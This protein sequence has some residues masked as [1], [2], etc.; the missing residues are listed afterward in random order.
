[1]LTPVYLLVRAAEQGGRIDDILLDASAKAA[2]VRTIV[3]MASVT[4]TCIA[5]AVPLAWLCVR[6]DVPFRRAW[7]VLLAL[8]LAVPSFIG[9]FVTVS[10]FGPGGML[11]DV[12]EPF[13]VERIPSLYG[14][15]GAWLTLSFFTYPYIFLTVHGALRRIDPS[16]EEAARTLGQGP[17][18][19]FARVTL[20]QLRPAIAA[21]AIL[22]ALYVLSE[23][24]AVSM[25]RYDTLTPLAYIQY[26]TSFDRSAAAVLGLPLLALAVALVLTE[27]LSQRRSRYYAQGQLRP[28]RTVRLGRWRWPAAAFCALVALLGIGAPV[29]VLAYWLIKGLSEGESTSFLGEAVWN[30]VQSSGLAA[31]LTVVAALPIATLSVRHPGRGPQLLT[32]LSYLGQSLPGITVALSL[33]YFAANFAGPIYQ[34]LGLLILAYAIRFLPEAMGACRASLLQVNPHTEE[35]ARGL[36][37]GRLRVF[38][39]ITLPQVLPGMT[40]GGVLA[41]LTAMKELQITLLLSPIGFET[42]A[43]QT[44]ASSREAFF[45]QAALP[46]LLLVGIAGASVLLMLRREKILA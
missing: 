25:L 5:L 20:P 12:L 27:A 34:T 14:F 30:S 22:V 39:R 42:L 31:L 13:G 28:A 35:A 45:T 44:W 41:F 24:G 1:M 17:L 32:R 38:T 9:G 36:G 29:T 6:S 40:A 10:A 11:Q 23:F 26:T 15:K 4:G 33:V 46:A 8:P 37:A 7:T 19:T 21:G 2:L 3:L 18:R 16:L 43:T